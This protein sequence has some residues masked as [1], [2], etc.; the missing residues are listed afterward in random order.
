[1][2]QI[3]PD[4]RIA[5]LLEALS[6]LLAM[7]ESFPSELCKMHPVVIDARAAIAK[8]KGEI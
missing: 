4:E 5:N 2:E 1:M 3:T 6:A 7:A 8:E